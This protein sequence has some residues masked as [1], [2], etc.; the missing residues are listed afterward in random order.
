MRRLRVFLFLLL[1][2]AVPLQ[3]YA[4][5]AQPLV[6]CPM[7]AAAMM[8]LVDA[9]AAHDCCEDAETA[10]KTGKTCKSGQPCQ[11]GGQHFSVYTSGLL[12][13]EPVPAT[14][15]PHIAAD[16]FSFDPAAAW[17]PPAQR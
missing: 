14:R 8:A 9:D 11:T 1:S 17:R 12:P 4:H 2:I 3:G 16:M 5:F 13:Q 15:F 7:G 6:P 10:A